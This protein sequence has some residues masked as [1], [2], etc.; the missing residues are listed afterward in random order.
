MPI[1]AFVSE[2]QRALLLQNEQGQRFSP[3]QKPDN[4]PDAEDQCTH[5]EDRFET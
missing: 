5:Q 2:V 1:A 4:I 3:C